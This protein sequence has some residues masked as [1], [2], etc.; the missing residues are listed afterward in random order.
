MPE[1]YD[2]THDDYG[3]IA[4]AHG[5]LWEHGGFKIGIPYRSP[6]MIKLDKKTGEVSYIAEGFLKDSEKKGLGYEL[7][8][9]SICGAGCPIG[10]NRYAVQRMRDLH[11]GIINLD[12]DSYE[13]FVPEI[14]EDIFEKIVPR[15]GG[16]FRG[17]VYDYFDMNESRLF[18]LE[19]FLKVFAED[20]YKDVKKQQ[21]KEL[22][23]LAANLDGT[24]GVKKH[25]FLKRVIEEKER[26][27]FT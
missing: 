14:P 21:I 13:E 20:G 3:D 7:K 1:G 27:I 2:F 12:N 25:E 23:T 15:D 16:F 5:I 18:P 8:F 17:D 26:I 6:H 4:G 22:E 19:N 11:V 24:C 9:V 10:K